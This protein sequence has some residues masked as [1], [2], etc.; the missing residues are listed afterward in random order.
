MSPA[1]PV[2]RVALLLMAVLAAGCARKQPV[3]S[4]PVAVRTFELSTA[5]ARR[6][7]TYSATLQARSQ[8]D[9]AFRLGGYVTNVSSVDSARRPAGRGRR[10]EAGRPLQSGDRVTRGTLLASI[11]Q[12]DFKERYSELSGMSAEVSSSYQ[13]ANTDY[14]RAQKLFDQGSIAQA[15][16]DAA[17]ARRDS[18]SGAAAAASARVGQAA[19]VMGDTQLRA[20]LDGIVLER[21]V[22][23]GALVNP[24]A[25]AFVIADTSTMKVTF[26]VPDGVQRDLT[27]GMPATVTTSASNRMFEGMI[28][29]VAAQADPR[30]R[31]FDIEVSIDN[32][33]GA[34]KVG[35]VA[36]VQLG[37][38]SSGKE[39]N[40][41]VLVPLAA[42]V[43]P[44]EGVGYGVFVVEE[45]GVAH[46]RRVELGELVANR[47]EV[48]GLKANDRIVT[49][50][51]TLIEEGQRVN[52]IP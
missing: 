24:G 8:V 18:F 51:A 23:V 41:A 2:R 9:L 15:E 7:L 29:R 14:Q 19:I 16:L 12:S 32:A 36:S 49:V 17:K 50:G 11:R 48:R 5:T 35:M 22:E 52:V 43:R 31:V 21:R 6:S 25:P 1:S 4:P 45:P 28:T 47:V 26:G 37:K 40:E 39:A 27:I 10:A 34:L 44:P 30:T 42:V 38:P 46:R 13:K 33:D 20:P 3:E